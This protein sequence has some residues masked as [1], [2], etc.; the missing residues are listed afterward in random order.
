MTVVSLGQVPDTFVYDV[1]NLRGVNDRS[2]EFYRCSGEQISLSNDNLK[3]CLSR[4]LRNQNDD[5]IYPIRKIATKNELEI[6]CAYDPNER[7]SS[8]LKL[9]IDKSGKVSNIE[10]LSHCIESLPERDL[11]SIISKVIWR[12]ALKNL[13]PVAS[14]LVIEIIYE[15]DLCHQEIWAKKKREL[16]RRFPNYRKELMST[17]VEKGVMW[18]LE[19]LTPMMAFQNENSL[20]T[21]FNKVEKSCSAYIDSLDLKF[22]ELTKEA[23]EKDCQKTEEVV[24]KWDSQFYQEM[25]KTLKQELRQ[26]TK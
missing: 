16:Y 11:K 13:E 5:I 6:G 4:S 3:F 14:K 18:D 25:D 1:F 23:L 20:S 8:L 26:N 9:T 19:V 21:A 22:I 10:T 15:N 24:K 12:S 17:Y 7:Y 2:P